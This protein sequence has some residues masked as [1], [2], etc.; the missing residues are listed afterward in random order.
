MEM[1]TAIPASFDAIVQ[2]CPDW[3][4]NAARASFLFFFI[5]SVAWL[6][7]WWLTFRGL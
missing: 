4:K 3:L 1:Q 6:A 2:Q 5:K 7:A